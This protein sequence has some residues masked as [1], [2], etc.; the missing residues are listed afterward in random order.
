[1]GSITNTNSNGRLGL[2]ILEGET[3]HN[4]INTLRSEYTKKTYAPALAAYMKYKNFTNLVQLFNED[5]KHIQSNVIDYILYLKEVRKLSSQTLFIT[6]AALKHFYDMNDVL[7]NWKKI[8]RFI[9]VLV[10]TVK[11]R[12]YTKQEIRKM[13]EKCDERKKVMILLQTSAGLRVGALPDLEIKHLTKLDKY[14]TYKLVVYGGT[15]DEYCCFCTPECRTAIDNYLGYR[16]RSG[17]KLRPESPL[18]REQFDKTN[19]FTPKARHVSKDTISKSI[20]QVLLDAGI[21]TRLKTSSPNNDN[22]SRSKRYVVMLDH[23]FRKFYDTTM[24]KAGVSPLY[25]ELLEGHRIRGV[26]DSY[27]KPTD[28][29]LLDGNEKM[30]GYISAVDDLTIDDSHRP[31]RQ[32]SELKKEGDQIQRLRQEKDS[33]MQTMKQKY[34]E[35]SSTLQNI[36]TVIS[37]LE[38]PVDKNKIAQQ[39][40]LK[41]NYKPN[42]Q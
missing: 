4:F 22:N 8:N 36:L 19:P 30:L 23:G 40:I 37:N 26:K 39:L 11:D 31:Q 2:P 13:L 28:V 41:G 34:E 3:Y 12:A 27:F 32:M 24:T 5:I 35:M 18:I 20:R 29:D 10:R 38:Q 14:K 9:G 15:P 16:Q 21:R 17:E 33:E 42:H 6:S 1:L 25:I 7:L